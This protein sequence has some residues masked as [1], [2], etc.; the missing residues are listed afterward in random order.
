MNENK[1][2]LRIKSETYSKIKMLSK[3]KYTSINYIINTAIEE[4]CDRNDEKMIS[5][6]ER[7]TAKCQRV[8]HQTFKNDIN[9][10]MEKRK[11]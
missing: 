1:F 4:Y 5:N 6:D 7:S 2:A 3:Q 10:K 11:N 9:K 8:I